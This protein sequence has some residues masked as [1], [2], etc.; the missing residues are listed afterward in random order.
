MLFRHVIFA[1]QILSS[2]LQRTLAMVVLHHYTNGIFIMN[3]ILG[4]FPYWEDP[5]KIRGICFL[6]HEGPSA[7]GQI[8]LS[9]ETAQ[10][11]NPLNKHLRNSNFNG[12]WNCAYKNGL[13]LVGTISSTLLFCRTTG[14]LELEGASTLRPGQHTCSHEQS[15]ELS[16]MIYNFRLQNEIYNKLKD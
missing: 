12:A 8:I 1:S 3:K 10:K 14:L 13:V 6:R 15:R 16:H 5:G 4:F 11:M 2:Q 7:I 9:C